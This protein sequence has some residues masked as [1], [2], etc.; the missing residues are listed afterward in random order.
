MSRTNSVWQ[1]LD[2]WTVLLYTILVL[3]GWLSIYGAS[4]NFDNASIFSFSERSG[5]QLVWIGASFIIAFVLIMA[6]DRIYETFA[7]PVYVIM[8]LLLVVTIAIAPEIKGSRSWLVFGP[9]SLQPAEF[10]KF[11]TSLALARLFGSYNFV[12]WKFNSIIKVA[13]IILLPMVCILLQKETGSSLVYTALLLVLYREGMPGMILFSG[14]CAVV[15]FVLGVKFGDV[16]WGVTDAGAFLVV[17]II[18]IISIGLILYYQKDG[19]SARNILIAILVA[20]GVAYLIP[21]FNADVVIDYSELALGL[22]VAIGIYLIILSMYKKSGRYMLVF[23][24]C[25]L[26]IGFFYSV[27]YVF[28]NVMEPHQ[29]TR[30]KVALGMEDD[31]KGAGYNVNQSKIAIGSGGFVG[32]G[33][34]NGTQT[35]LKYVPEQDTDFIFCTIGEEQGFIGSA[36]VLLLFLVLILRL[37]AL[38]E[39]QRTIFARVY[40]YCVASI[41]FFHVAINIGM[42]LGLTPVIGIPLPFFSY[43]GSSLWG[44]SILLF[45]F[46]R[47]DAGRMEKLAE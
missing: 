25:A 45:I 37:I 47:L 4:Y 46:L 20:F 35:K 7:Y 40:G 31:P 14:F 29:Q 21:I 43:G 19:N 28:D 32:K 10:A 39:R 33:F 9:I 16:I 8:I 6:D 11:A 5:K 24:F 41:L 12:F 15:F 44:F 38:A 30:I 34:L 27:D 36:A 23:V 3:G 13:G 42:V 1:Q 26:S 2:W 17:F 22:L 18:I